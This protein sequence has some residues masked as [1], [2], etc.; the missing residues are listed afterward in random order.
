MDEREC[1]CVSVIQNLTYRPTND[2][3]YLTRNEV[4]TIV[5]FSLKML[6]CR[7]RAIPV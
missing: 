3:T 6:R 2:T 5:P 1:V 7:A 4:R